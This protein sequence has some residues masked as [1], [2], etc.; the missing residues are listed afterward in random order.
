MS[1]DLGDLEKVMNF[2]NSAVQWYENKL[3]IWLGCSFE[4]DQGQ[5]IDMNYIYLQVW[6]TGHITHIQTIFTIL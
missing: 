6:Y 5:V 3:M 1:L 2:C 4:N